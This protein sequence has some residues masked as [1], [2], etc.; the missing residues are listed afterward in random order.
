MCPVSFA[1][2]SIINKTLLGGLPDLSECVRACRYVG[3]CT[4]HAY[5]PCVP[6]VSVSELGP[7]MSALPLGLHLP[8]PCHRIFYLSSASSF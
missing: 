5:F 3:V 1:G 6:C 8:F 2:V 7:G 4:P